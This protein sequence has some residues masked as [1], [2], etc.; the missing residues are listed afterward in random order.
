MLFLVTGKNL[1]L[2]GKEIKEK[3]LFLVEKQDYT[4]DSQL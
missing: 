4:L 3:I 1:W 2:L